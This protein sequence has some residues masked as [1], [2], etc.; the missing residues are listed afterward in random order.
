MV[1]RLADA[2]R[3]RATFFDQCV[4]ALA[5]WV[6]GEEDV[7]EVDQI[8]TTTPTSIGYMQENKMKPISKTRLQEIIKEELGLGACN[9]RSQD[10][11][12]RTAA[13]RYGRNEAEMGK[14]S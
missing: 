12:M 5:A 8:P 13:E 14:K 2:G 4:Q 1:K 11:D 10:R 3:H 9:R 6:S 7:H